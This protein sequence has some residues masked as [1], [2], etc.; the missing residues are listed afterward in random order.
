ML[1]HTGSDSPM[2]DAPLPVDDP[3]QRQPDIAIATRELGWSPKVELE[4]GLAATIAYF[5]TRGQEAAQ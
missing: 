2:I 4:Q 3:L 5:R 1:R